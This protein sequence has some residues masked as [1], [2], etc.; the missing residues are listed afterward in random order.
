MNN[1][2]LF[3]LVKR[4]PSDTELFVWVDT[5]AC[6]LDHWHWKDTIFTD[7]RLKNISYLGTNEEFFAVNNVPFSQ[8]SRSGYWK[9]NL[10]T[11]F[12]QIK[13]VH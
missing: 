7:I 8:I 2:N 1:C 4:N 13:E 11:L 10:E 9:E 5:D 12:R 6:M 3:W